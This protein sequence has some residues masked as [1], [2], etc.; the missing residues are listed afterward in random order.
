MG[1]LSHLPIGPRCEPIDLS[2]YVLPRAEPLPMGRCVAELIPGDY[3]DDARQTQPILFGKT[4]RGHF[5]ATYT[6]QIIGH[7]TGPHG[8]ETLTSGDARV[9]LP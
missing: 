6:V 4:R 8:Y 9:V 3:E 1:D 5:K 7:L 2:T